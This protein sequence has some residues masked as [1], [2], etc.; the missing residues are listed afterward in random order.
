M[1][2]FGQVQAQ[3]GELLD[4]PRGKVAWWVDV[5]RALDHL[6]DAVRS[7]PGDLLDP[8]GFT[9]QLR[10]DAPHLMSRWTRLCQEGEALAGKVRHV[11]MMVG[12]KAAD[13][14]AVAEVTA[15]VREVLSQVRRYQQRT[16]EILLDAYERDFGGE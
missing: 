5:A 4:D 16:T 10:A 15:A 3:L 12:T 2:T 1:T 6:S 13:P 9:E 14:G 7:A 11:R 8:D